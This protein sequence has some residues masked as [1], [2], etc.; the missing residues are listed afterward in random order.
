[1]LNTADVKLCKKTLTSLLPIIKAFFFLLSEI[2]NP[3][4]NIYGSISD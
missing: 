3:E 1:M 4:E 2:T